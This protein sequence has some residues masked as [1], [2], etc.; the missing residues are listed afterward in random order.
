MNRDEFEL[1]Q[2]VSHP[3]YPD[4]GL[5]WMGKA[6]E[7]WYD[8]PHSRCLPRPIFDRGN[9][10][11]WE[12]IEIPTG[13]L[14]AFQAPPTRNPHNMAAYIAL[15]RAALEAGWPDNYASDLYH[16]DALT[17]GVH[18]DKVLGAEVEDGSPFGW[19][20][21]DHG[22]EF[23]RADVEIRSSPAVYWCRGEYLFFWW[24]GE[25]LKQLPSAATILDR[26]SHIQ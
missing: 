3:N 1:F 2:R 8:I 5:V 11:A 13:E 14:S 21:R 24:D 19:I 22:T 20:L 23:C 10:E 12:N 26:M 6:S 18:P 17:L 15:C 25:S 9:W 7:S 4:G 16:H